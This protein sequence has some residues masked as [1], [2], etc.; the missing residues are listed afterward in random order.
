MR[1]TKETAALAT[2]ELL[3]R[4]RKSPGISTTDL[5]GTKHFHGMRTLSSA[6][7]IKLL[8]SAGLQPTLE[9]A[10]NR[11]RYSWRT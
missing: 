1:L 9:G 2:Q 4:I 11:T 5:L 3:E 7:V 6:Q 8:R 10:G